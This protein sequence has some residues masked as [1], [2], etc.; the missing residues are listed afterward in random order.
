METSGRGK[1]N[2]GVGQESRGAENGPRFK[3]VAGRALAGAVEARVMVM[4]QNA[5]RRQR[6]AQGEQQGQPYLEVPHRSHPITTGGEGAFR[7]ET[8]GGGKGFRR[9]ARP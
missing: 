4:R 7:K 5:R 6:G 8:P 9:L 2:K 3:E 1:G